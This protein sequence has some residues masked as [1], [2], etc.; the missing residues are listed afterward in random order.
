ME[1]IKKVLDINLNSLSGYIKIGIASFLMAIIF[2]FMQDI[3][4]L[5]N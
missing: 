1:F 4:M 3:L 2:N 5:L